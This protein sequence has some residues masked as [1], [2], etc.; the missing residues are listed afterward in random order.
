MTES[1]RPE[2][3]AFVEAR[4]PGAAVLPLA[5]DASTRRFYRLSSPHGETRVLMDYGAPFEGQTDDA[6]LSLL[7]REAGLPVAAIEQAAPEPGCL[8]LADLGDRTLEQELRGRDRAGTEALYAAAIDLAVE[9]AVRGTEA[10]ERSD[11]AQG[12]SLDA[13]RFRFEMDF[14][15][16]HY[17]GSLRGVRP[18]PPGL[19]AALHALAEAA[20]APGPKVLCHRDFHSRNLMVLPDGSMAMVDIQDARWGPDSYDLASLLRD[21]YVDIEDAL[22]DRMRE[23]YRTSLPAPPPAEAFAVRY[24]IVAAERMI[25]AL[26]TFGYQATAL[27][28]SAYLSGVPRT[29]ARLRESLPSA[30]ETRCVA[31]ALEAEGLLEDPTAR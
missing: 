24:R 1:A 3:L 10:L 20:A 6:R 26:G 16:E 17:A 25:K 27:G 9:I 19:R 31:D 12:P 21:A 14:F 18:A 29:L 13:A 4:F 5:G 11:R 15:L 30:P 22:A 2:V 7:F 28:R 8:I 23:R